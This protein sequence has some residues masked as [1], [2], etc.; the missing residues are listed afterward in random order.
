MRAAIAAY[1]TEGMSIYKAAKQYNVPRMT[2]SDR[3][4]GK[5]SADPIVGHTCTTVLP[6]DEED[7][8]VNYIKF[9]HVRKFPVDRSQV[10][11]LA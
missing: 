2:L 1:K 7:S 10:M 3:V 4:H 9:A 8:L 5:V 11:T 6:K